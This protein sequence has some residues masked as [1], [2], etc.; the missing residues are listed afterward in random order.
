MARARRSRAATRRCGPRGRGRAG[1]RRCGRG[2]RPRTRR[3][4]RGCARSCRRSSRGWRR[5][6]RPIWRRGR[7][8][9]WS[10]WRARRPRRWRRCPGPLCAATLWELEFQLGLAYGA[11]KGPGDA[12]RASARF[13]LAWALDGERRP[14]GALY[15][16][17]V[18]LAFAQ[19]VDA[20]A[21]RPSRPV[22]VEV[23]PDD[24]RVA[25]DCRPLAADSGLR[26]GLHAVRVDA[27][28]HGVFAQVVEGAEVIRAAPG[29]TRR[30]S[31]D[32]GGSRGR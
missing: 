13:A 14:L 3:R 21:R 9:C 15:G 24:A 28:G 17:D 26:P 18:G 12:E 22:T 23:T 7:T 11:R 29:P 19:A 27:P 20:A 1:S 32:R 6:G 2:S 10:R 25:V 8:T 16:P 30:P 5:R 31:W 4:R